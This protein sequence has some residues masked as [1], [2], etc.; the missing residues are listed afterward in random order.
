[1]AIWCHSLTKRNI[2][3]ST[4]TFNALNNAFIFHFCS[5]NA[6]ITRSICSVTL[7]PFLSH[8][9]IRYFRVHFSP[10]CFYE[11]KSFNNEKRKTMNWEWVKA[12]W[13]IARRYKHTRTHWRIV[14]ENKDIKSTDGMY[15]GHLQNVL[16]CS[17]D[18]LPLPFPLPKEGVAL[19]V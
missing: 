1:M 2:K 17:M 6:L 13:N 18:L 14:R 7:F 19:Y 11:V 5:T 16:L 15:R 3:L 9:H 12:S 10:R 4:H 8:I